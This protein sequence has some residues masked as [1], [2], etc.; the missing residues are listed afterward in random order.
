MNRKGFPESYD[1]RALLQFLRDLKS[2]QPRTR[3][4]CLFT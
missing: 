1:L 3:G 4:A 2:G